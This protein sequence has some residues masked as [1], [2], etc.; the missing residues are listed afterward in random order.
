M[1][2]PQAPLSCKHLELRV[3]KAGH[4]VAMVTYCAKKIDSNILSN[5]WED[6]YRVCHNDP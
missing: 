1:G 2:G 5:D 4:I 6:Q 3:F